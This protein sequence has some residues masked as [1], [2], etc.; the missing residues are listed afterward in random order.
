[1][2]VILHIHRPI[3]EMSGQW[4]KPHDSRGSDKRHRGVT[5]VCGAAG[6]NRS[7]RSLPPPRRRTPHEFRGGGPLDHKIKRFAME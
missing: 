4:L 7:V 6:T 5:R 2:V 3:S 1:V